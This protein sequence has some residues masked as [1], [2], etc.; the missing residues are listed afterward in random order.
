M[1]ASAI[2]WLSLIFMAY[3]GYQTYILTKYIG[4]PLDRIE[5]RLDS[6]TPKMPDI[7]AE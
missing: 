5:Q 7:H 2:G 6:I 1:D 4:K 3:I